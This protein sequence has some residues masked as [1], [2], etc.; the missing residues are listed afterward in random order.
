M[1]EAIG[2]PVITRATPMR[3][4]CRAREVVVTAREAIVARMEGRHV[5]KREWEALRAILTAR[6]PMAVA[7]IQEEDEWK[8]KY[9]VRQVAEA[10]M[11]MQDSATQYVEDR[12]RAT[13]AAKARA[14]AE[15]EERWGPVCNKWD[16]RGR[17]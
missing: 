6:V 12:R 14:H 2:R 3:E 15:D 10:I 9:E 5:M 8:Y 17:I 1:N 16:A 4:W 13:R 11:R 7:A